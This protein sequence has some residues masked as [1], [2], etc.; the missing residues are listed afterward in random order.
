M[1]GPTSSRVKYIN[2]VVKPMIEGLLIKSGGTTFLIQDEE[3]L[4]V[5]KWYKEVFGAWDEKTKMYVS[6]TSYGEVVLTPDDVNPARMNL[7]I[8][9]KGESVKKFIALIQKV[10]MKYYR[11][12]KVTRLPLSDRDVYKTAICMIR[13]ENLQS[14]SDLFNP[15]E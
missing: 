8:R 9:Y 1:T 5:P 12:E 11:G 2:I 13:M 6:L 14:I 15:R 3:V 7:I 4:V 10:L